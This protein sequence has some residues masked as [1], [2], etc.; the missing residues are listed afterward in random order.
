MGY[1]FWRVLT[2][3]TGL[4]VFLAPLHLADDVDGD[5]RMG[6]VALLWVLCAATSSILKAIE[7]RKPL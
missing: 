4:N 5:L 6:F 1:Q 2:Y 7:E 3:G